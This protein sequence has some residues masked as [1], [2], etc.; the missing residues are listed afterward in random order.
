MMPL[1]DSKDRISGEQGMREK[2]ERASSSTENAREEDYEEEEGDYVDR[3]WRRIVVV[4]HGE[5]WAVR[6]EK[7]AQQARDRSDLGLILW[8]QNDQTGLK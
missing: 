5:L 4:P 6:L 7:L 2:I 1:Q 3:R 8:A